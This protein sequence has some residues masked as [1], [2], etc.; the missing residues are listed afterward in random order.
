MSKLLSQLEDVEMRFHELT[1]QMADP[2]VASNIDKLRTL[3]QERARLE[4][5]VDLYVKYRDGL[6]ELKGAKELLEE[7]ADAEMTA[8]AKEEIKTLTATLEALEEQLNTELLPKDP[9]DEKDVVLEIRAGAGGDE[10]ALFAAEL[11][12]AYGR[13]AQTKGR[14]VETMNVSAGTQGGFKAVIASVSGHEVYSQM[15]FE[16][17][18]HRV[19]RVPAT[20]SQGRIHTST[21]TVVVLP[22]AEEVDVKIDPNDLRID[23]KRASGHG[24]QSVNTTDSAVRIVHLPTNI[25]VECQDEKSQH[26]NKAK[27]MT[28][29][30]SRLFEIERKKRQEEDS[31]AR[32]SMVGMGDRSD[33]VRTYNFPQDRVTDHRIGLTLHNLPK[34]MSGDFDPLVTA[35]RTHDQAERLKDNE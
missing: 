15:K 11:F 26:K 14:K 4:K 22:E 23:V 7:S 18:V 12:D 24:G 2:A 20:E 35:L 34:I 17:G 19:Q 9:M 29:L 33:K 25:I 10:A 21:V 32:R 6:E 8:M 5:V 31:E 28:V 1:E 27:A 13:I 3:G 16:G 30:R